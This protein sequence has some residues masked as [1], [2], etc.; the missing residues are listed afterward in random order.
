MPLDALQ[1]YQE[2][3]GNLAGIMG[4]CSVPASWKRHRKIGSSSEV[5][6]KCLHPS[7]MP[8]ITDNVS[9][10]NI[11]REW[12]CK[13]SADGEKASLKAAQ[14]ALE[15]VLPEIKKVDGLGSVQRVVCGGCLDFKVVVK[16]PADKF[17]DWEKTKFA[18]EEAFLGKLKG[19]EGI[20]IV[21]TQTYTL[22][23]I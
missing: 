1:L 8:A 3:R 12:R 11:A 19:I 15:E 21:E 7:R 5:V 6:R 17:G 20:S 4:L 18:P 9:F 2:F 13:W 23:E 22:E 10:N 14:A 16:L